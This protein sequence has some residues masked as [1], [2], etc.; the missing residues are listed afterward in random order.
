MAARSVMLFAALGV[1]LAIP[2]IWS[3]SGD[4]RSAN[5]DGG[6]MIQGWSFRPV[7]PEAAAVRRDRQFPTRSRAIRPDIYGRRSSLPRSSAQMRPPRNPFVHIERSG[8][9]KAVPITRGT[10][11]GFRFRPDERESPYGV[12]GTGLVAP[13]SPASPDLHSQFRPMKPRRKPTYEELEAEHQQ[14]PAPVQPLMPYPPV[15]PPP[16]P[17]YWG[18]W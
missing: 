3:I 11:L 4:A 15:T 10:E 6:E 9:R 5:G 8:A 17:G 7:E 1:A 2:G 16:L 13:G 12:P 18:R 14:F